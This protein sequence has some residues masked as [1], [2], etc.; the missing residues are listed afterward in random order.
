MKFYSNH[1][2][3]PALRILI[4]RKRKLK[5]TTAELAIELLGD[6]YD[7]NR[8]QLDMGSINLTIANVLRT[9]GWIQTTERRRMAGR[10]VLVFARG[11]GTYQAIR[12]RADPRNRDEFADILG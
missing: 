1:I 8:D 11:E 7:G 12:R 2:D 5:V 4:R 6:R 9:M 10:D 3:L